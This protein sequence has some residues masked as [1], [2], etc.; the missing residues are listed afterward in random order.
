MKR[1][2]ILVSHCPFQFPSGQ[3][4]EREGSSIPE[5]TAD[6]SCCPNVH[7][8]TIRPCGS[9]AAHPPS[10]TVASQFHLLVCSYDSSL[11]FPQPFH[12]NHYYPSHSPEH[13]CKFIL[14]DVPELLWDNLQGHFQSKNGK[15]SAAKA[16]SKL[17][18]MLLL[19]AV[20]IF[21]VFWFSGWITGTFWWS[22]FNNG[23]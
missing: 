6:S 14:C 17:T 8:A 1:C 20:V 22:Y 21:A 12:T 2:V 7:H 5:P 18:L 11:G 10:T 13:S 9:T 4:R 19:V 16:N 15:Y 23:Y 3:A